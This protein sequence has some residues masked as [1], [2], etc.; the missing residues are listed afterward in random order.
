MFVNLS[1]VN[2]IAIKL[3]TKSTQGKESCYMGPISS[4]ETLGSVRFHPLGRVR[5]S[6]GCTSGASKNTVAW[7]PTVEN[8]VQLVW[9]WS[10]VSAFTKSPPGNSNVQTEL[11]TIDR[12]F[13]FEKSSKMFYE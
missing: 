12:E 5:L 8:L 13:C 10:L 2:Y 11:R 9:W 4:S 6:S 3:K 7:D 1:Y